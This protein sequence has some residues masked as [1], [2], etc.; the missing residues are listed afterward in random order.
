MASVSEYALGRS[1]ATTC[2]RFRVRTATYHD[3]CRMPLLLHMAVWL[4]RTDSASRDD[5]RHR[6]TLA[7]WNKR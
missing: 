3:Q 2:L 4:L 1:R 5:L 6:E 7:R